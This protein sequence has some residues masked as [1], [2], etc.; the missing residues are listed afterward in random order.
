MPTYVSAPSTHV[1]PSGLACQ[2]SARL[3]AGKEGRTSFP[4][5]PGWLAAGVGTIPAF[6]R[7]RDIIMA[8]SKG[9]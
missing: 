1:S 6:T 7:L 3:Q 9:W 8:S 5:L 2:G 4:S